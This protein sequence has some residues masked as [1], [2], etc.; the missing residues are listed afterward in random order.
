VSGSNDL[1]LIIGDC[2]Q[3]QLYYDGNN[4]I[5]GSTLNPPSSGCSSALDSWFALRIGGTTY[6][7]ESNNW[8]TKSTVGSQSGNTYNGTTV[9]TRT[10]NRRVYELDLNWEYTAPNKFFTIDWQVT[11]PTGN[12]NNVMFYIG[13]DSMV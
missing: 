6:W 4:N 13:N 3:F 9:L 7:S 12:T 8:T 2:G 5:Y 10:V 11:I 1:K